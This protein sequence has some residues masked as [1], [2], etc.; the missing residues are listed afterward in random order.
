MSEKADKTDDKPT[1]LS[2]TI[3]KGHDFK[4]L[5]EKGHFKATFSHTKS[6]KV[7]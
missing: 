6:K 4:V 5:V 3:M 1:A 2:K 7:A